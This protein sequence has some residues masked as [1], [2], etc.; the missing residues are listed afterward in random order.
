MKGK[1]LF[2]LEILFI[3]AVTYSHSY[4]IERYPLLMPNVRPTTPELYLCT[5]I[6]IDSTKNYYIVGFEPNATMAT[7]H[8]ML[9]YGCSQPGSSKPVWNCG[10][11]AHALDTG[12]ETASPCSEG[13]QIIYAWARD[14]PKLILPDDVGFKVGGTSSIKY[15]V[16]QVHYSHIDEFKDGSTDDSGIFLHYTLKPHKKLA[17]V[18]LLGT[19]GKIPPKSTEYME[20]ACTLHE[21]KTI[22]PIAYRTHTHSLGRVVSGYVIKPENEWLELGKRDPLSPQMFYPVHK[23]I[24]ITRGDTLAARCTMESN[25]TTWTHIGAT[26]AD[27][28]C[29]FYLMY[30]VKD[31]EPLEM[32]YCFTSGPP[33]YYWQ[34]AGLVGIPER[35]ASTL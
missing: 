31:D 23:K 26:N 33:T 8:H 9:L 30:Y 12:S 4:N 27:E 13:S 19:S 5:P 6:K 17:G 22:Y 10:E 18:L 35:E 11:M 20:S 3:V 34:N 28:M 2:I 1:Y 25:R 15:L 14:A 24:P 7:A 16:L 29:N 32:K 21:D